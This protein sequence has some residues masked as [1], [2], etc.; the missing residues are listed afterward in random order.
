MNDIFS[1]M[2]D[3]CVLVYLDDILIYSDNMEQHREHVQEV[4]RRLRKN[5]LF[6]Q[7]DK[8]EFHTNSVEYLGYMLS[9]A[10]LSMADYKVKDIQSFLGFTNFY[11]R[12]IFNY[13][14]IGRASCR[15]RV[16]P[17]V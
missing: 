15:E 16:S 9:P 11:R 17:Y 13:S 3:V 2:L 6:A 1:D 4:L 8:C 10:G 14:K 12:F 7:A 5:H